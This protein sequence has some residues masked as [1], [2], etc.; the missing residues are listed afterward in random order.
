MGQRGLPYTVGDTDYVETPAPIQIASDDWQ[1]GD[2]LEATHSQAST[3]GGI[4]PGMRYIFRE[5]DGSWI[6]VNSVDGVEHSITCVVAAFR[7][8]ERPIVPQAPTRVLPPPTR[9]DWQP[10]DVL[11]RNQSGGNMA[12][13]EGLRTGYPG[14]SFVIRELTGNDSV[15]LNTLTGEQVG[16]RYSRQYF[17]W[18]SAELQPE[19]AGTPAPAVTQVVEAPASHRQWQAGDVIRRHGR[20]MRINGNEVDREGQLFTIRRISTYDPSSIDVNDA[21]GTELSS[22]SANYFTWVERP[23]TVAPAPVLQP[24]SLTPT[25]WQVGDTLEIIDHQSLNG[26]DRH[27][28]SSNI[29]TRGNYFIL[30]TPLLSSSSTFYL[31]LPTGEELTTGFGSQAFRFYSR[32]SPSAMPIAVEQP[33]ADPSALP[34]NTAVGSR[35]LYLRNGRNPVGASIITRTSSGSTRYN[36]WLDDNQGGN[37]QADASQLRVLEQEPEVPALGESLRNGIWLDVVGVSKQ[38]LDTFVGIL[39]ERGYNIYHASQ[40]NGYGTVKTGVKNDGDGRRG[41]LYMDSG[42]NAYLYRFNGTA[43]RG[44]L[45]RD[46]NKMLHIVGYREGKKKEK[47]EVLPVPTVPLA[48]LPPFFIVE[49]TD[50]AVVTAEQQTAKFNA[51]GYTGFGGKY[52]L[53]ANNTVIGTE[54]KGV[55]EA[56]KAKHDCLWLKTSSDRLLLGQ[57]FTNRKAMFQSAAAKQRFAIDVTASG[58]HLIRAF[59]A[60]MNSLGYSQLNTEKTEGLFILV[61]GGHL[62]PDQPC[63]WQ[64][65]DTYYKRA[66]LFDLSEPAV[67]GKSTKSGWD[68]MNERLANKGV[69]LPVLDMADLDRPIVAGDKVVLADNSVNPDLPETEADLRQHANGKSYLVKAI[70]NG[71]CQLET[72]FLLHPSRLQLLETPKGMQNGDLVTL[73]EDYAGLPVGGTYTLMS[74]NLVN[75]KGEAFAVPVNKFVPLSQQALTSNLLASYKLTLPVVAKILNPNAVAYQDE[76]VLSTA[77]PLNNQELA[78]WTEDTPEK[79]AYYKREDFQAILPVGSKESP[80]AILSKGTTKETTT[81]EVLGNATFTLAE[82]ESLLA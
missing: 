58:P 28:H 78:F 39:G 13:S 52:T 24:G 15:Y 46:W 77:W 4:E 32:P 65:A 54:L 59:Q 60:C 42:G 18:V 17:D 47:P 9:Q 3:P 26:E 68:K 66:T 2:V 40:N 37:T 49:Q 50:E 55:A 12:D 29:L 62:F 30:R 70:T 11:R 82:L 41:G 64:Y 73:I 43:A 57:L 8:I 34:P 27:I 36:L 72:G 10:G 74:G 53:F 19:V 14:D 5:R 1:L 63:S 48:K 56:F 45:L 25:Q 20:L 67:E 76:V 71:L 75:S 51:A 61:N 69:A 80:K 7:F 79:D 38:E 22:Y 6:G 35:V 44:S 16:G 81:L 33:T 31:N 23:G 21:D